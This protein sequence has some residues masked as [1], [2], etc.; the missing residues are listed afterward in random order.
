MTDR[1]R[2]ARSLE[3]HHPGA[4]VV[5]R[6]SHPALF[7][8]RPI[9]CS[10][11]SSV[12]LCSLLSGTHPS[13][14]LSPGLCPFCELSRRPSGESRYLVFRRIGPV[15]GSSSHHSALNASKRPTHNPFTS[16]CIDG[17]A[18]RCASRRG[19]SALIA[20][21]T[22]RER[23]RADIVTGDRPSR[24]GAG[25][26]C[27][28]LGPRKRGSPSVGRSGARLMNRRVATRTRL[29]EVLHSRMLSARWTRFV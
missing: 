21:S 7:S 25:A 2:W 28:R 5:L 27:D 20:T 29:G 6:T 18:S 11:V 17:T 12:T 9:L 14:S 15:P 10:P 4:L 8:P 13:P 19:L 23:A 1:T 16:D 24:H 26:E 22:G 3:H